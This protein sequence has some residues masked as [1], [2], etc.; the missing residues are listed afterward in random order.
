ML[1][2]GLVLV[3]LAKLING[4]SCPCEVRNHVLS[5]EPNT[6]YNFPEDIADCG[7]DKDEVKLIQLFEQPLIQ[8]NDLA[9]ADFN[10]LNGILISYCPELSS[11]SSNVFAGVPD[12]SI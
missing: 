12:L 11:I 7:Y 5:C 8:L 1:Y 6:I 9:F 3:F 2:L 4:S 10:N